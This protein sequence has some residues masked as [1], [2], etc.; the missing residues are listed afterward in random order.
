MPLTLNCVCP[1]ADIAVCELTAL[2]WVLTL[3]ESFVGSPII[4]ASHTL[5]LWANKDDPAAPAIVLI[6][7][8]FG[9]YEYDLPIADWAPLFDKWMVELSTTSSLYQVPDPA[10]SAYDQMWAGYYIRQ[11]FIC[12]NPANPDA[13]TNQSEKSYSSEPQDSTRCEPLTGDLRVICYAGQGVGSLFYKST[14]LSTCGG[15]TITDKTFSPPAVAVPKV[16]I[17]SGN[18]C[19]CASGGSGNYSY[20]QV[21][22]QL[23]CGMSVDQNSGCIVGIANGKCAGTKEF[24]FSVVDLNTHETANV[25]CGALGLTCGSGGFG[26]QAY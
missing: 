20:E 10:F 1:D 24:E 2:T 15:C 11:D 26:N 7:P 9:I 17:S 22:G 13:T 6:D 19:L 18:W 21:K 14:S 23:P 12:T 16:D 25:I 5:V 8:T 4:T 3:D